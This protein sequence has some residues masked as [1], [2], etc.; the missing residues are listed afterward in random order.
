MSSK[1]YDIL[2]TSNGVIDIIAVAQKDG[3]MTTTPFLA[4]F[5]DNQNYKNYYCELMV[6]NS[7]FK[8][9][10]I[11]ENME[12]YF[13]EYNQT[14][15][16]IEGAD[17]ITPVIK[18]GDNKSISAG[19]GNDNT[20]VLKS[21]LS[22][23]PKV[24]NVLKKFRLAIINR[25]LLDSLPEDEKKTLFDQKEEK[26]I[27]Y[28]LE[29][30]Y[31]PNDTRDI[32]VL[33]NNK[34]I[35]TKVA[36]GI[37]EDFEN[38]SKNNQNPNVTGG[39][40]T[41][42]S[43]TWIEFFSVITDLE[44]KQTGEQTIL[45]RK[46]TKRPCSRILKTMELKKGKNTITYILKDLKDKTCQKLECI[47]YLY[48]SHDKFIICDI[49]GSIWENQIKGV[50]ANCLS[51]QNSVSKEACLFYNKLYENGYNLL[52]LSEKSFTY[53]NW[54]KNMVNKKIKDSGT[55][56]MPDCPLFLSPYKNDLSY[57]T[58]SMEK[59]QQKT[60]QVVAE[61]FQAKTPFV[62]GFGEKN[63]SI[64]SFMG[65]ELKKSRIYYRSGDWVYRYDGKLK[66]TYETLVKYCDRIFPNRKGTK[67]QDADDLLR[68]IT[69][70]AEE[71]KNLNGDAKDSG[72]KSKTPNRK[73]SNQASPMKSPDDT[74]F[75]SA[76]LYN[77]INFTGTL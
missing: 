38:V 74:E 44:I 15:E 52:Y 58:E 7:C 6:N 17:N 50:V 68:K 47:L 24:S 12:A 31:N 42:K 27:V 16:K 20:T 67:E 13:I 57:S 3:S 22:K 48:S 26:D 18:G 66:F 76:N 37:L 23:D 4:K 54:I 71:R 25:E 45:L 65:I 14:V 41:G 49:D 64:A 30:K 40:K 56:N 33:Y 59:I 2:P 77:D 34:P 46:R 61:C 75:K 8:E 36:I 32:V 60:L 51:R 39:S 55:R 63:G 9:M 1:N 69:W 11:D 29:N 21:Q 72:D 5:N 70:A 73:K 10:E 62:A 53:Y 19:S 35:E 28:W 43:T